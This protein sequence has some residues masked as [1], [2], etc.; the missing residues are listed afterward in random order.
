ME[1]VL[2]VEYRE[3]KSDRRF[4]I[5]PSLIAR[6]T[7]GTALGIKARGKFLE[8]DKLVIAVAVTNGTF[9]WESFHFYNEV[10]TN[11]GKTVSGRISYKLPL[12][13]DFEAGASGMIGPQ[14]RAADNAN[15]IWFWGGDLLWRYRNLHVKAQY[16]QGFSPGEAGQGVYALR[17]RHGGYLEADLMVLPWLG[18]L[19]RPELRDAFVSLG[20]ERAY[21]TKSWRAT[22][23]A[24]LAFSESVVLKAEYLRNGEYGG[25]PE[26]D[27]DVFTSSLVLAY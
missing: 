22:V 1:S 16:L 15:N 8:D 13:G 26:I 12:P 25:I 23:G 27:N 10:D 20:S 17:L 14:D 18:F 21:L 11:S 24:R 9:T 19:V 4:G 5:T 3:R 2:G 7:T 6:Y